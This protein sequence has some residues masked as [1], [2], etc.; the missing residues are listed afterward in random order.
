MRPKEQKKEMRNEQSLRG[1]WSK[2]T[3]TCVMGVPGGGGERRKHL[4][5]EWLKWP[6]I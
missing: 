1:R 3:D 6:Q 5:K 4:K 2:C